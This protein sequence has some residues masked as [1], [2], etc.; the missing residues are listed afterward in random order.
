MKTKKKRRLDKRL[1]GVFFAVL[2]LH[3]YVLWVFYQEFKEQ[4]NWDATLAKGD[5]I[6]STRVLTP[7]QFARETRSSRSIVESLA[8]PISQKPKD[9]ARYLGERTQRVEKQT[10]AKGFGS[11]TGGTK[12]ENSPEA[13]KK[14]KPSLEK[15]GL[16]SGLSP[17]LRELP[18]KP[19]SAGEGGDGLLRKGSMDLLEDNVAIGASTL[20]NTDEYVYASFFNRLKAEVGPRWEPLIQMIINSKRKIQPGFYRTEVIFVLDAEGDVQDVNIK[21]PS[22]Y[23]PF[24]EAARSS[25]RQVLR[26]KNPPSG[27]RAADGSYRVQLG[28]VVSLGGSG[29]FRVNY[30]ADPRY[31]NPTE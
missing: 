27:L 17:S 22:G 21:N 30:E 12:G 29:G 26:V 7:E 13:Q 15:L 18:D 20:L 8:A 3:L 9:Q 28:F 25:V 16:S 5:Q 4:L 6:M 11:A 31:R 10:V 23:G 24:D 14:S 2:C 19:K 1:W